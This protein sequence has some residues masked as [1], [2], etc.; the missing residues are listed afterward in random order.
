VGRRNTLRADT[1]G[2]WIGNLT[3][4]AIRLAPGLELSASIYNLFDRRYADPGAAEHAQDA[5]AQNGRTGRI[6][7]SYAF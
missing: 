6:K 5:I 7:L 1:A 4:S 3:M 2:Y